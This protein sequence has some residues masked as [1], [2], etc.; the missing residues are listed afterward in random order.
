MCGVGGIIGESIS[1]EEKQ[2]A[3][4]LM[5]RALRHRGPDDEGIWISQSGVCGLTA[6]RLAIL[7]LS[8]AGHQ[9]MSTSDGH[10]A[11]AFNGEIYNFREL[12]S[13]SFVNG[14]AFRSDGDTEVVLRAFTQ[15]GPSCVNKLRGMFGFAVWDEQ[16][17]SCFLARDPFGIK[18]LYYY[19]DPHRQL[20]VFASEIR[21]LLTSQLVPRNL[22]ATGLLGYL[23]YGSVQ[24]PDT[25]LQGVQCLPAGSTLEFSS[26][27]VSINRYW[28]PDF[29][30]SVS[31]E[32]FDQ[33]RAAGTVREALIDSVRAHFISDVPVG[34]FLSG[35]IDS[36]AIAT[37]A[38][39]GQPSA[40]LRTFC[41][42]VD[43]P[44]LNETE[45]ARKT[46]NLLKTD[47]SEAQ[48]DATR[49]KEMFTNSLDHVDQP[50]VDGFNTFAVSKVAH[51]HGLKVVLSGLGGDELFAGYPTFRNIPRLLSANRILGGA[52]SV[53]RNT[54]LSLLRHMKTPR[55][56]RLR[57]LL[58]KPDGNSLEGTYQA[59]RGIFAADEAKRLV[60]QITGQEVSEI[61]NPADSE[62]D[63]DLQNAISQLELE[64]YMRNQLLRDSDVM[65]M[66]WSLELRVPF[67]DRVMF[68]K[69]REIPW[70]IRLQSGKK[71]LLDALP[72]VPQWIRDQRKRGFMFPFA[73]WGVADWVDAAHLGARYHLS[74]ETSWYQLWCLFV[75]EA[76]WRQVTS[77]A[78]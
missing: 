74:G 71:L 37:A 26:G 28:R 59:Y 70:P 76:W 65:S 61:N 53:R 45:L 68:E 78:R 19:H 3:L 58:E 77:C 21:V 67:V 23:L 15:L 11:I 27:R 1:R 12:R 42:G 60:L 69:L 49:A 10:Y 24:E 7:D 54:A 46:A 40:D 34:I 20:F 33:N 52:Q 56:G 41:I 2:V 47:H 36:T 64:R 14:Y 13:H 32:R 63:V 43:D 39:A 35:G 22:S 17:K 57:A 31:Q 9:P 48:L 73:R 44:R 62:E 66:A 6:T 30:K 55:W 51:E 16:N 4:N 25:M 29:P 38:R 8:P 18:P 5:M 72:E 50:T 75:F